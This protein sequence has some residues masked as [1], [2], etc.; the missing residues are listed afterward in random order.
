M[1]G[2]SNTNETGRKSIPN[3]ETDLNLMRKYPD[4]VKKLRG[5]QELL[6]DYQ[7][8]IHSLHEKI[9]QCRKKPNFKSSEEYKSAT[10]ELKVMKGMF[11]SA[12]DKFYQQ[13]WTTEEVKKLL[14]YYEEVL[15]NLEKDINPE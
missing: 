2:F 10:N 12:T 4:L 5:L 15:A 14:Q 1:S 6:L 3:P 9:K 8:K 7:D 13:D 11:K